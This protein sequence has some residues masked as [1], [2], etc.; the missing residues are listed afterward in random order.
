MLKI[1]S[2]ETGAESGYGVRNIHTRIRLVY[3]EAYGL[4]YRGNEWG[5]VSVSLRFPKE[6]RDKG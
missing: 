4:E 5:G 2:E 1:L 6:R 3:G